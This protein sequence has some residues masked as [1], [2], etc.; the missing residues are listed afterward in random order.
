MYTNI[1]INSAEF[2]LKHSLECGQIFR[3]NY[4]DG[5]YYVVVRDNVIKIRQDNDNLMFTGNNEK[6]NKEFIGNYFRLDDDYIKIIKNI[7]KDKII[8]KAINAYPG[9][10]LIRQDPW[11]CLMSYVCS[12][13]T[14]IPMI[15]RNLNEM[16]KY[17]GR[18]IIFDD[19]VFYSFPN[20]GDVNDKNKI[21]KCGVGFRCDYLYKIN[22]MINKNKDYFN[23]IKKLDYE[24]AKKELLKLPGVGE[25]IADCVLLFSLDFTQAFPVDT[26][27]RKFMVNNYFDNDKKANNNKIG[28]FARDYFG[29]HAGY[30]QELL[31]YYNRTKAQS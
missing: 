16:S 6:V 29:E 4:L 28:E 25:K 17:F 7:N 20:V 5:W 18:E 3:W 27:V 24:S 9:L 13:I 21:K 22:N 19:K 1:K 2:S 11:E 30:A 31:F 12:S 23:E 14:K 10:R 26:W 8:E 15:K